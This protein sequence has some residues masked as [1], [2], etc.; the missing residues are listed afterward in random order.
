MLDEK[1]VIEALKKVIDPELGISIVDMQ[2]VDNVKID[3]GNVS[4]EFHL[5]S[6][7]CPFAGQIV[8]EIETTLSNMNG[9]K[10][11]KIKVAEYK[12]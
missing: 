11:V 7:Y 10:S 12:R 6:P 1:S 8:S 4:V 5:T 9:V 3:N 2:L